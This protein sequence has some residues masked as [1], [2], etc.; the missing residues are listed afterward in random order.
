MRSFCLAVALV[1]SLL[2]GG[3]KTAAAQAI[4]RDVNVTNSKELVDGL[5]AAASVFAQSKGTE[6]YRIMLAAGTYF[7]SNI[8]I[9]SPLVLVGQPFSSG[10]PPTIVVRHHLCYA[11]VGLGL[12]IVLL[13]SPH[14]TSTQ[15]C[16]FGNSNTNTATAL[17]VA[18]GG[19]SIAN[20]LFTRCIN[21]AIWVD[22]STAGPLDP[23]DVNIS[24]CSFVENGGLSGGGAITTVEA[25]LM[26]SNR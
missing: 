1:L 9:T 19:V 3:Q 20:I 14:L 24:R 7:S 10:S 15:N 16:D 18:S 8:T 4:F 12:C 26:I 5:S 21:S 25:N 17:I 13:S 23:L 6:I 22:L 2:V 11:R